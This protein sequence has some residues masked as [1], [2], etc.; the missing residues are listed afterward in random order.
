M[1]LRVALALL[2]AGVARAGDP[3][4]VFGFGPRGAAMGGAFTALSDDATAAM[5]N[6]AGSALARDPTLVLGYG[7]ALIDLELDGEDAGVN[8][9][10]ALSFAI[11]FP[12]RVGTVDFG[13][14]F[15]LYLPD[16]F[17]V[18]LYVLPPEQPRF[19]MLDNDPHRIVFNPTISLRPVRWL[20]IG[21]GVTLLGDAAGNGI[22][23]DLSSRGG[24]AA[25]DSSLDV[26]LPTRAAPV[27][28]VLVMPTDRLRLG[29]SWRGAI[30]LAIRI[31]VIANVEFSD[32][33]EGD[34]IISVRAVNFYTPHRVSAGAA[35]ALTPRT[36]V[37]ADAT[38]LRWSDYRGDTVDLQTLVDLNTASPLVLTSVPRQRFRDVVVPRAGVE[39]RRAHG[40]R[41][42]SAWRAGAYYERSPVPDQTGFTSYA[43]NDRVVAA[44]GAGLELVPR[45]G[46]ILVKPMALDATFQW[47]QLLPRDVRKDDVAG[48]TGDF[49][50]GG[51]I[52]QGSL[53]WTVKF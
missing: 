34:S 31:D 32:V 48:P 4:D 22:T 43:D 37:A 33:V 15:A 5:Y 2:A 36:T 8:N 14:S 24:E 25:G 21:G 20:A 38:Y 40:S 30:D 50:S 23:F 6:P 12:F 10:H 41:L 27:A 46:G 49:S 9:A 52:V 45:P 3:I 44:L 16:Q 13:T 1:G 17:A 53:M 51:R 47:H 35:Y 18:R 11:G 42:A 39:H 7:A 26:E 28:G 19:L 29:A